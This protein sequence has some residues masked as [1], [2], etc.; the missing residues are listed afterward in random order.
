VSTPDTVTADIDLAIGSRR[1]RAKVSVPAGRVPVRHVLPLVRSLADASAAAACEEA[2]AACRPV[3]CKAGCAAC[4]RHLVALTE[5]EA[6]Q[7]AELV[8]ALPEPRRTAVRARFASALE[9]LAAAGLLDELRAAGGWLDDRLHPLCLDYRS[10]EVA[11]PF[12][13][14]ETCSIYAERPLVCRAYQVVSPPE[15]CGG[16]AGKVAVIQPPL[17]VWAAAACVGGDAPAE[18]P[19]WVP[20]VLALEWVA[21]HPD[22]PA[23]PG[24]E[25]LRRLFER[26]TK[27]SLPAPPTS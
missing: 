19:A 17:A 16:G 21:A 20:L 23:A 27:R 15:N 4:C 22:E 24:P 1:L 2:A 11:C 13:E 6:R 9:R 25:L 14:D 26:L 10:Q 5:P 18:E 3:S 7:L 8:E 12:L